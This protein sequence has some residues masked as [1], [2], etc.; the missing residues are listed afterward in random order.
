M[1]HFLEH[2]GVLEQKLAHFNERIHDPI[3]HFDCRFAAEDGREHGN[4]LL[5]EDVGKGAAQV[6]F[7]RY[8]ILRY[9]LLDL[10]NRELEHEIVGEAVGIAFHLLPEADRF[11]AEKYSQV[12][13]QQNLDTA[14][15][16]NSG[17]DLMSGQLNDKRG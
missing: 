9:H 8:R 13:V 3:A 12:R 7:G 2:L 4:T 11:D 15:C 16:I 17:C 10:L 1:F 14:N 5:R 6:L